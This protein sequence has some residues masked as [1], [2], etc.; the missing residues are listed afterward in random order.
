MFC[1]YGWLKKRKRVSGRRFRFEF[2]IEWEWERKRV[3]CGLG[4]T[5][6][7]LF[8]AGQGRIG[9]GYEDVL[10]SGTPRKAGK[11]DAVDVVDV[12]SDY[13]AW[14]R[15]ASDSLGPHGCRE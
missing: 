10:R 8:G 1:G 11:A 12:Q 4:E 9:R 2:E 7:L 3:V 6:H 14:P 15:G 5:G 13:L